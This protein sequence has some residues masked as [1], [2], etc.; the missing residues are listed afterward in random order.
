MAN[1]VT[2]PDQTQVRIKSTK[3]ARATGSTPA[4]PQA[5][6]SGHETKQLKSTAPMWSPSRAPSRSSLSPTSSTCW[7]MWIKRSCRSS[8]RKC[9]THPARMAS[10]NVGEIWA[11]LRMSNTTLAPR[12]RIM[13]NNR[14]TCLNNHTQKPHKASRSQSRAHMKHLSLRLP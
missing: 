1:N 4:N 5:S 6:P 8:D 12:E 14:N 11:V 2:H 10:P 3:Y 13:L 7:G 9:L